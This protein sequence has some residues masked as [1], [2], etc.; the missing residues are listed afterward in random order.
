MVL[1]HGSAVY[2]IRVDNPDGVQR[3]IGHAKLDG[4][5]LGQRPLVIRLIDDGQVHQV[6]VTL[7]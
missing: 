6:I 7:A 3:G 5:D 2:E 4:Q 1:R